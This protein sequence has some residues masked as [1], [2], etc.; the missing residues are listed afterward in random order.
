MGI[1]PLPPPTRRANGNGAKHRFLH[2]GCEGIG[3]DGMV[4]LDAR[5]EL[6][7][8]GRSG[9]QRRSSVSVTVTVTIRERVSRSHRLDRIGIRAG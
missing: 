5:G 6:N 7:G 4:R 8:D 2:V 1:A 9:S 3:E